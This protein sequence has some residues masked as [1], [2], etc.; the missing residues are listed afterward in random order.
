MHFKMISNN[1]DWNSG[2][3]ILLRD[4]CR[5]KCW[6]VSEGCQD[7]AEFKGEWLGW[8]SYLF[9]KYLCPIHFYLKG[10]YYFC[11]CPTSLSSYISGIE[12][13]VPLIVSD[14]KLSILSPR[15]LLK[16]SRCVADSRIAG[17]TGPQFLNGQCILSF[18][19]L[20]GCPPKSCM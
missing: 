19:S 8:I 9:P 10:C 16:C 4:F 13:L 17:A 18:P 14:M 12:T 7:V 6:N 5:L 3:E 15:A 11:F 2:W 1:K 20:S